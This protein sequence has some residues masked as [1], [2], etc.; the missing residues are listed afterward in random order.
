[1]ASQSAPDSAARSR[2][3]PLAV[4]RHVDDRR[5]RS[6]KAWPMARPGAAR[7]GPSAPVATGLGAGACASSREIGEDQ[8]GN[9]IDR[10]PGVVAGRHDASLSASLP[11]PRPSSATVLRALALRS[12]A[13]S[14]TSARKG[15]SA[16]VMRAAGRAWMPL[17]AVTRTLRAKQ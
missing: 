5:P 12:A 10:G 9:C 15:F 13:C 3:G 14:A 17:A 2:G 4:D 16:A 8:L 6:W 11:T 1:M 7:T